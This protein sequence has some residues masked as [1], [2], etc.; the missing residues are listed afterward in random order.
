[1]EWPRIIVHADMDAFY[2]AVEQLDDPS[3]RGLP[4]MVGGASD[5]GVVLTASYEAR[6]Y[7]VGSAMPMARARR[8]CPQAVIVPPRFGRYMEVSQQVFSAFDGFSPSVEPLSLDEAFLD[9]T[10]AQGIFGAPERMARLIQE[11]VHQATGGLNASVG[12]SGTKYVAKV[13]SDLR[14]PKGLVVVPQAKAREFLAPLP[15][16]R[17]WGA[18]PKMAARIR[19]LGLETIGDVAAADPDMLEHQLGS[20]GPHFRALALACDPREVFARRGAQSRGGASG[21]W[22]VTP[23]TV[24]RS[25][26][27]YDARPMRSGDGCESAGST[28]EAYGSS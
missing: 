3:L 16:S 6:I 7:G 28:P 11:A 10:G 14:K 20:A 27:A 15:V 21:P 4:I 24:K 17:L 23:P 5:R 1:M 2:A 9:M 26:I 25:S 8:L 12:V 22:L 19:A 13:A 18:G